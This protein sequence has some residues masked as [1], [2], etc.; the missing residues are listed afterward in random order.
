MNENIPILLAL[1]VIVAIAALAWRA[2]AVDEQRQRPV[3]TAIA[4]LAGLLTGGSVATVSANSAAEQVQEELQS[5]LDQVQSQVREDIAEATD[6]VQDQVQSDIEDA[7]D[8][9]QAEVQQDINKAADSVTDE[10]QGAPPGGRG[11]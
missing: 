5:D 6:Q 1:G 4:L 9:V 7:A 10:I 2:S 3:I 8:E 11:G